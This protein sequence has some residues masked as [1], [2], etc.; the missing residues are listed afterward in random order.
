M[1]IATEAEAPAQLPATRP[2]FFRLPKPGV[3]DPHFGFSRS[4][5]YNGEERGWWK[6]VRI[7]DRGKGRGVTLIPYADVATFVR[8]AAKKGAESNA[9]FESSRGDCPVVRTGSPDA[10]QNKNT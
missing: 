9:G 2:E 6:L 5:Y 8:E 1:P 7:R 3:G 10:S 4:F